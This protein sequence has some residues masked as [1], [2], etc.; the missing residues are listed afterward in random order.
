MPYQQ[1]KIRVPIVLVQI[2]YLD[3]H[4][5]SIARSV[6]VGSIYDRQSDDAIK[7]LHKQLNKS[8]FTS[9]ISRLEDASWIDDFV[10]ATTRGYPWNGWQV[11]EV[12]PRR[13][14]DVNANVSVT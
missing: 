6:L 10:S 9:H 7:Y 1:H 12:L 3:K 13:C 4:V 2:T 8:Y 5:Q 14:L 11:E